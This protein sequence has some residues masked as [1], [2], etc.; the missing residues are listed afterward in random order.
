MRRRGACAHGD[1]MSL[2]RIASLVIGTVLV[3]TVNAQSEPV[4]TAESAHNQKTG[5]LDADG[6]PL[7]PG[8]IA[9]LGTRRWRIGEC[10]LLFSTDGRFAIAVGNKPWII[11]AASGKARRGLDVIARNAFLTPDNKTLIVAGSKG[12]DRGL[13]FLD[14]ETGKELRRVPCDGYG[15][16]WSADGKRMA[17]WHQHEVNGT[18]HIA[19]WDL[20]SG[21]EMRRWERIRGAVAL[22]PDGKTLAVRPGPHIVLFDAASGKEL[23]RWESPNGGGGDTG[24]NKRFAYSPDGKVIA[25][26]EQNRVT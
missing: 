22:A 23:R 4:A 8:A 2:A 9:R 3:P 18:G 20:D 24:A 21:K 11:D 7:P 16:S 10:P 26:T 13:Y 19:G 1:R 14:V 6:D 17:C 12:Q 25:S 15:C 5:Y